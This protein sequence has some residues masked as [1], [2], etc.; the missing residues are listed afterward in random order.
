[1]HF[2]DRNYAAK[3]QVEIVIGADRVMRINIDGACA[4]RIMLVGKTNG[5]TNNCRIDTRND[6]PEYANVFADENRLSDLIEALS[7]IESWSK[8]YPLSVFPEPNFARAQQLLEAGGMTLD[9]IS[10]S[11]MRH[12][13]EGVGEIARTALRH[14]S[15]E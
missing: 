10:A 11:A 12:V 5:D 9:N 14:S 8:A 15:G 7:R 3:Q 1:M 2:P 13:I 4:I 6:L